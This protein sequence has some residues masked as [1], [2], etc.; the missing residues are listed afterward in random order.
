MEIKDIINIAAIVLSPIIA[1]VVT[2][3]L[4][5]RSD[6]KK[7]K[8][9]IIKSLQYQVRLDKKLDLILAM[10]KSV[11]YKNITAQD[12]QRVYVP[13]GFAED[14]EKQRKYTDMQYQGMELL[15]QMLQKQAGEMGNK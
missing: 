10:C 8:I 2:I 15:M 9:A 3:F 7:E 6:K 5:N 13:K 4:Q 11:N 1:V 12:L 14:G